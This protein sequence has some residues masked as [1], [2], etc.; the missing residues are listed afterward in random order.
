MPRAAVAPRPAGAAPCPV[1]A[2]SRP[3]RLPTHPPTPRRVSPSTASPLASPF[4]S[5]HPDRNECSN[6]LLVPAG[7]HTGSPKRSPHCSRLSPSSGPPLLTLASSPLAISQ[8]PCNTAMRPWRAAIDRVDGGA[9][10]CPP[11]MLPPAH[12]MRRPPTAAILHA[13]ARYFGVKCPHL[14]ALLTQAAAAAMAADSSV[15]RAL[16]LA[17]ASAAAGSLLT[18]AVFRRWHAGGRRQHEAGLQERA[19]NGEERHAD[20]LDASPRKE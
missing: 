2:A 8:C 13:T 15:S 19:L 17:G 9:P 4:A 14:L 16:L 18:Y 10:M 20:P 7:D 6:P 12:D 1:L 3:S 5:S 11:C